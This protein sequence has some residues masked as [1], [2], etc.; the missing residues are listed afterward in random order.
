LIFGIASGLV[1]LLLFFQGSTQ[2]ARTE[3]NGSTLRE[4]AYPAAGER[5]FVAG[6]VLV[7]LEEGATPR[8]LRELNARTGARVLKDLPDSGLSVV[9]LPPGLAVAEAVRRYEGSPDVEYAQPN[10][11]LY[12]ARTADDPYYDLLYGL[13]NTGQTGGAPDADIDAPEAWNA[14]VG[15]PGTVVAVIDQGVDIGHPDLREN[16]WTNPDETPGNGVDDDANGYVDDVNGWD[17]RN[18]DASVYDPDP[19]TGEGDGHGTHVA[20]TI[21]ARGNNA[22]G[23]TGVTWQAQVMPLKFLGAES[24]TTADA[25]AAVDYAV[26]EGAKISN[27]SWVGGAYNQALYD[28]ISA[29]D[30]AGHLFVAAAGN[31][32]ADSDATTYYPAGYDLPNV[33]TVA[34]TDDGDR[35]AAFS[36]Y[37]AR[38][39]DLAAPGVRIASTYPNNQ[40]VY[41]SGTSMAAPHVSGVAALIKSRFPGADDAS[42]KGRILNFADKK[43]SLEGKVATGARLNAVNAVQGTTT[44][45]LTAP[46]ISPLRPEPGSSTTDRTP[47]VVA[48]VRDGEAELRKAHIRLFVDGE[49]Q[50]EFAYDVERGRLSFTAGPLSYD[51]HVVKFTARDAFGNAAA[52]SWAFKVER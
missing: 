17:F 26:R 39:V 40:Y 30:A 11:L 41:L 38:S 4:A 5:E 9:E 15:T 21:A 29:A 48:T 42:M 3:T 35:L 2:E 22:A 25:V 31:D 50:T 12:P 13:H 36:N 37:G 19:V 28:A 33:L 47:N 20:G 18:D 32:G 52:K 14:T 10:Y 23:V 16:V 34:A 44:P 8:D 6:E 24:G 45:D 43:A 46:E 51:R 1:A 49:Q 27:N 7:K